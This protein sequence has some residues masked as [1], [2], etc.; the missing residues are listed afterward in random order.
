MK[1]PAHYNEKR[2][3]AFK[4]ATGLK[5]SKASSS[6][7]GKDTPIPTRFDHTLIWRNASGQF[8]ITT[9]PYISENSTNRDF[10]NDWKSHGFD[11]VE[12]D[13]GI[14]LWNPP[15]CRLFLLTPKKSPARLGELLKI[16]NELEKNI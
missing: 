11:F 1:I 14:G 3:L 12:A 7:F 2:F 8:V 13:Y 15:H 10:F 6:V 5:E 4:Q 9:E 16:V